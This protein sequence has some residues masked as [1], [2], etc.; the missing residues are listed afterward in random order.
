M[1]KTVEEY[2]DVFPG[3]VVNGLP[4]ITFSSRMETAHGINGN[5]TLATAEKG[6]KILNA[7]VESICVFLENFIPWTPE[8]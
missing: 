3:A 4:K 2:C 8:K 1:D 6:E 5:S 7:M